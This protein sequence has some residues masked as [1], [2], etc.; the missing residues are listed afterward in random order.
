MIQSYDYIQNVTKEYPLLADVCGRQHCVYDDLRLVLPPKVLVSMIP[1]HRAVHSI[2]WVR[3]K[4]FK[5]VVD[6]ACLA[7][8][9]DRHQPS[10]EHR[11]VYSRSVKLLH[12]LPARN[13]AIYD[14]VTPVELNRLILL[15]NPSGRY[16]KL[17]RGCREC[18]LFWLHLWPPAGL[19]SGMETS[20]IQVT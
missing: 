16:R 2:S 19:S 12:F 7:L 9:R 18:L 6:A 14:S 11:F 10:L 8:Y 17:F 20:S 3:P 15:I 5:M 13:F 4:T 1:R